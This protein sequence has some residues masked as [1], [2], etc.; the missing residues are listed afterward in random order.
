MGWAVATALLIVFSVSAVY[1]IARR[2]SD[3]QSI[4]SDQGGKQVVSAARPE[5]PPIET[6]PI[7]TED[8]PRH[9]TIRKGYRTIHSL[10]NSAP[11]ISAPTAV[12]TELTIQTDGAEPDVVPSRAS[13][14]EK[15]LRVE[16]QTANP[17]I[18]I[19]WFAPQQTKSTSSS[20]KGT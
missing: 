4:A 7:K 5:T 19:I 20:S 11:G 15:T 18:R 16:M 1:F 6:G 8:A 10:R 17:N 13:S 3:S 12:T 14:A 2:G 9:I